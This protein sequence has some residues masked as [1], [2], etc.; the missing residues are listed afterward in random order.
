MSDWRDKYGKRK[1]ILM[2]DLNEY[3]GD[4]GALYDFC[5][6]NYLVDSVALLNLDIEHEPIYRYGPKQIDYILTTPTLAD[7]AIKWGG[8]GIT[9]TIT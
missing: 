6:E 4:K 2:V 8:G 1:I 9:F 3:I 5:V 7:L